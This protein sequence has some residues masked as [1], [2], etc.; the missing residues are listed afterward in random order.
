M[1]GETTVG[2]L[3]GVVGLTLTAI[4]MAGMRVRWAMP[5]PLNPF[6]WLYLGMIGAWVVLCLVAMRNE[7]GR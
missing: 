1:K 6:A 3:M 4:G 2:I 5:L 7:G